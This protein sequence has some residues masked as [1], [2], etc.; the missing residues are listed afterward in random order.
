MSSDKK[1]EK[2]ITNVPDNVD[3]RIIKLGLRLSKG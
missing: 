1:K 2:S 3:G